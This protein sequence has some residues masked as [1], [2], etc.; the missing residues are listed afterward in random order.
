MVNIQIMLCGF[1]LTSAMLTFMASIYIYRNHDSIC[2]YF[3]FLCLGI[4]FYSF[5]YAMELYSDSMSRMLF[6]NL[7]QYI[8]LPFLPALWIMFTLEYNHK[9][10]RFITKMG[11]FLIPILTIIFRYTSNINHLYYLSTQ[12]ITNTYFPV[13]YIEKGPWYWVHVVFSTSCFI[14]AN[15]LYFNM[16]RRSTGSI[17]RQSLIMLIASFLPWVSLVLDLLNISPLNIDYG[18]FALTFSVILFFIAFL[19]YQFLNIK[20]LARDKVFELTNDGIIVLDI[21][22]N[23]IDFNPSAASIYSV[24]RENVIGKDVRG[25]LGE[26]KGL[27]HSIL[28]NVE[29]QCD[30]KQ[31]K[32]NYSVNTVKISEPNDREVGYIVTLTD[33]TK[34]M[35]IMEE[36]KHLA[37]RDALTGIFNRRYFFELSSHELEKS[38]RYKHPISMI[39]LDLDFFKKINDNYGHQAGDAVLKEVAGVCMNSIRSTDILGRYGGEEFI[40]FLPETTLTD[41]QI[42]SSRIL[43]NIS[44]AAIL[45]EGECIKVT[46]SL[47]I[48][49]VN[50]VTVESL[51]YF[52]KYADEALYLAKS[53]GRNCVRSI[54]SA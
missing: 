34:Y 8:G 19:R 41:C 4:S 26:Y 45:Y 13:L 24:L 35:D 21:N 2:K 23:I 51:D 54:V 49:G 43:S 42:I 50:S 5:G 28:N 14:V 10:L 9:P 30:L 12:V 1:L 31:P 37:S 32:G 22:Y 17:R 33:I 27:I 36:L 11:I 48:T 46:A 6:W 15:Y 40:V 16:Y 7:V 52:L 47:G 39:I 3:S 20:P 53:D 25:V 18:T 38:R 44:A 29:S